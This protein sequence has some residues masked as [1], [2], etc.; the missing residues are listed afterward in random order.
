MDELVL[1][2]SYEITFLMLISITILVYFRSIN[3]K[4][5]EKNKISLQLAGF[6]TTIAAFHYYYMI[7]SQG[8]PVA[9]RYF[10]WFF[11]TPILLIDLCILLDILDKNLIIQIVSLNS[12]MLLFGYLGELNTL[13]M[14]NSTILGFIPFAL[15]FY[16]IKNKMNE[17]IKNKKY[18]EKQIQE[19]NNL[20]YVFTVLWTLYGVNHLVPNMEIKNISYNVMDLITKGFFGLYI[21]KRSINI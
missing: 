13:S 7:S 18:S 1:K 16:L 11:T 21:F 8:S 2:K 19:N 10:D 6:V 12:A 5:T 3:N 15:M 9:Y 4:I 20:Y 14:L 17:N